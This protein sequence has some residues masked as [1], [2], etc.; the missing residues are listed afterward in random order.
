MR[1]CFIWCIPFETAR[2]SHPRGNG[3]SCSRVYTGTDIG[4][5]IGTDN[6]E[7]DQHVCIVGST[8]DPQF[9]MG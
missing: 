9:R 1:P 7:A 8:W 3:G 6:R 2:P 5:D 4:T